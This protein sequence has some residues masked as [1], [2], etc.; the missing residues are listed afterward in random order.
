MK[1]SSS[2]IK[3]LQ[4]VRCYSKH[5]KDWIISLILKSVKL[6]CLPDLSICSTS[7]V[8][9]FV[10]MCFFIN[11]ASNDYTLFHR[12][13]Y[14]YALTMTALLLHGLQLSRAKQMI[15]HADVNECQSDTARCFSN[16]TCVNKSPGYC[17]YC[18]Q[19]FYGNG[20][21][22]LKKGKNNEDTRGLCLPPIRSKLMCTSLRSLPVDNIPHCASH[23]AVISSR[24]SPMGNH[25]MSWVRYHDFIPRPALCRGGKFLKM[26]L[27]IKSR[28]LCHISPRL[29]HTITYKI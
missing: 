15:W 12:E 1:N 7:P 16:S 29:S 11:L 24:P 5:A 13:L 17:C 3:L 28:H 23:T 4:Q 14:L 26:F 22:C 10:Q 8:P 20:I 2:Q 21:T 27:W 19:G 6:G 18:P 9:A 25:N